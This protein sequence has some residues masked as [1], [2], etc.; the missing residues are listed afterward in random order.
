MSH[1][2][3]NLHRPGRHSDRP[4]VAIEADSEPL[5]TVRYRDRKPAYPLTAEGVRQAGRDLYDSGQHD[6]SYSS[7]ADFP[8]EY[9]SALDVRVLLEGAFVARAEEVGDTSFSG[10]PL[11]FEGAILRF[12]KDVR[13][14]EVATEGE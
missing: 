14:A 7:S 9:G 2:V 10:I 5:L 12:L 13:E 1:V 4:Y 11:G 8:Q 6:W 3:E